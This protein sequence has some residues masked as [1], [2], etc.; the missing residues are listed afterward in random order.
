VRV[1][2][3]VSRRSGSLASL[4]EGNRRRVIDA[5][6]E[7]G[8]ASR[9]ELARITGLSRSTVS[10]IVTD[11]LESGLAN[12]REGSVDGEV[13]AG[14]PPVMVAL[15]SK[16]GLA[17]G[18]D[19][20]HRHLR[21]AVSDLSHTVLAETWRELDVDHSADEGLDTAA[22]F[23]DD[24]LA[25]AEVDRNR[26][27]GVGMGL[28]API[29]RATGAV[30][31]SSILPGWVG[32][33]AAAEASRRLNLP[34]QVENDANLGALAELVWGAG[35]GRSDLA[36]I[37]VSSGIGAGLISGGRLQHGVGG[38]AGEIG[39]TVLADGGPVC[40]C[41]N[42]GCLETLASSRAI[43][44]L[45]SASRGEVISTRRLLELSAAGDAAAQRLIGDAGR[46]IGIAV[47]NLCNL[48]NPECVIVGGDL[49]GAGEVL[50][51]PLRETAR[52]NAIPSAG[53][54]LEVTGGVLGERAELLGA[55][56]LVMHESERFAAPEVVVGR[57]A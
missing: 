55:L 42:R 18:I 33:D 45:L 51:E 19:F 50:L 40:R 41:G 31:A 12:E 24:V 29:D 27:I 54:A 8:V 16:A 5:L 30:Q 17:L 57:A 7:R 53:E 52:R 22:A 47:A 37:K 23:V 3:P 9:A 26:V 46:A 25:E 56:A 49:S 44:Q 38:T 34:V 14:R 20:G 32:V 43:A 6:R 35:R 21:V 36:Y 39:H 10:T 13:H 4:R 2:A 1:I 15:N 11:L 28:P 48:L